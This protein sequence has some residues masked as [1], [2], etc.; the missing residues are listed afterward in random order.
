MYLFVHYVGKSTTIDWNK[1]NWRTLQID[2]IDL[3]LSESTYTG[4][5]HTENVCSKPPS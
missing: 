4:P 3:E 2:D 5:N 1:E